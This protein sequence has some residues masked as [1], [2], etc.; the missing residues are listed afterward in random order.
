MGIN[1]ATQ[2]FREDLASLVNNSGLPIC[3]IH[4]VLSEATE[5]AGKIL[6][7]TVQSERQQE[8]KGKEESENGN[9]E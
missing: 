7:A 3:I 8:Q 6:V 1:L 9:V 4:S 2:N 5:T